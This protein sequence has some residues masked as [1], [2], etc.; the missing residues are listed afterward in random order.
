MG[1]FKEPVENSGFILGAKSLRM[2]EGV[3]PDVVAVC[4]LAIKYS[5]YDWAITEGVRT[6]ERQKE[7]FES[8]EKVTN[9]MHSKHLKDPATGFGRAI[10]FMAVGDLDGDGDVDA[11][12]KKHTW[13]KEIYTSIAGAFKKAAKELGKKIKWGGDFK[14]KNGKPFF[15]GPHIEKAE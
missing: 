1:V 4:K 14:R 10:D 7:L 13:D 12:D 6:Y 8:P 9:T 2:L 5:P 3:D 11:Q 15:D